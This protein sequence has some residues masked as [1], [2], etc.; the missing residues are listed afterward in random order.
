MHCFTFSRNLGELLLSIESFYTIL[1]WFRLLL[2]LICCTHLQKVLQ[3]KC[4][5]FYCIYCQPY[6]KISLNHSIHQYKHLSRFLTHKLQGNIFSP[7]YSTNT[8]LH[9][10]STAA[11]STTPRTKLS[12]TYYFRNNFII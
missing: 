1:Q 2:V 5:G 4:S 6:E 8:N 11:I 10:I 9:E 12:R 7:I 3:K